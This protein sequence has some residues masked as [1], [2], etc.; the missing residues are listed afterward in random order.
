[1][2]LVPVTAVKSNRD[3]MCMRNVSPT[4]DIYNNILS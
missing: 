1:M 4:A 2:A 3:K